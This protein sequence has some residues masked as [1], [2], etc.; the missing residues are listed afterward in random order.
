LNSFNLLGLIY[1]NEYIIKKFDK[2]NSFE[3]GL[4]RYEKYITSFW[5]CIEKDSKEKLPLPEDWILTEHLLDEELFFQR[6][7]C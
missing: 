1:L 2:K 5:K 6:L 3:K 4:Q 7:I